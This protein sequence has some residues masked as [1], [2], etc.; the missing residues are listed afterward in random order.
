MEYVSVLHVPLDFTFVMLAKD[1]FAQSLNSR[2]Q[3]HEAAK[4]TVA[5]VCLIKR[6][7]ICEH[8]S[9][10]ERRTPAH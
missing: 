4:A 8:Q 7:S 6:D 1:Y 2:L 9:A 5:H 10:V 3:S